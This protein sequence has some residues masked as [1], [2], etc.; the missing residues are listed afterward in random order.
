MKAYCRGATGLAVLRCSRAWVAMLCALVLPSAFAASL[1]AQEGGGFRLELD[2]GGHRGVIRALAFD[3]AGRWLFSASDDKTVRVWDVAEGR[4]AMT[5]RGQIGDGEEGMIFAVAPS[6]DSAA[7]AVA[8]Y[9]APVGAA[10]GHGVIRIHDRRSGRLTQRLE[11]RRLPVFALAYDA[12]RDELV[13]AG[14][15]GAVQRWRAPFSEAPEALPAL[16]AD[17]RRVVA[18]GWALGG[19]RL[20]AATGDYGLRIWDAQTGTPLAPP[21]AATLWDAG[22]V[23]LAVSPDGAA[24]AIGGEAG[25]VQVRAAEDGRLLAALPEVAFRPD[26]L[27]FLDDERLLIGCGYRCLPGQASLVVHWP[28]GAV[29]AEHGGLEGLATAA[30]VAPD[31]TVALAGGWRHEIRLWQPAGGAPDRVLVGEG[32]PVFAVAL[33]PDGDGIAWG[34][35]HPCPER[36]ACPEVMGPLEGMLPLPAGARR[37]DVPQPHGAAAADWLRARH[38]AKPWGLRAVSD[39]RFETAELELQGPGGLRTLYKRGGTDGWYHAAFTLLPEAGALVTGGGNGFLGVHRLDDLSLVRVLEGHSADVTAM[40]AAEAEG[41]L[42]TGGTDQTIRLWNLVTGE[43]VASFFFTGTA[44]GD[45]WIVWTPQ[46]YYHSSPGGD[47]LIGWHINQGADREGRLMRSYQ[48][49]RHLHS[50]EIVERALRL[51][52]ARDAALELRGTDGELE[53]LLARPAPE[54]EMR[55]VEEVAVEPGFAVIELL[56]GAGAAEVDFAVLVNDRR[57]AAQPV[58]GAAP[59]AQRYVIPVEAGENA[60]LVTAEDE[61]GYITTRGAEAIAAAPQSAMAGGRLR[62]AVVGIQDYPLLP[63][64]C[65]GRSCDLSFPLADAVAF[66]EVLERHAA[67]LFSGVERLVMLNEGALARSPREAAA[68]AAL[69]GQTRVIEPEARAVTFELMDFLEEAQDPRDTTVVF[70]AGHGIVL[71]EDYYIIPSDGQRRDAQSWRMASLVDWRSIQQAMERAQGRRV[72]VLDT[73]HA[74][75][76][77]NQRLEKDAADARISVFAAT[78]PTELAGE[79]ARLGHG[80]FTHAMVEGLRG[81]ARSADGVWALG[82]AQFVSDEVRRLSGETQEPMFHF[83]QMRNFLMARP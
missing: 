57:V 74:A 42:V 76:A 58:P 50:P 75:G 4:S 56:E 3:D 38:V 63:D 54:F 46:G 14:Q 16:E 10:E 65:N 41:V 39:G 7:V 62:I 20:V 33:A 81:A 80:I 40:A 25:L 73:C 22:L 83:P 26:A 82:L 29:V 70:I 79:T 77:F 47:R 61:A 5:L 55:L 44:P 1:Q 19:A 9:L 13:A 66:L 15:G 36:V 31:G 67:P 43:L 2:T 8:G 23:A 72:L 37:L 59:G 35:A 28:S 11:G 60:I 27:A 24:I 49:K 17:A 53:R 68:L 48:L 18:M 69:G 34:T 78:G 6:A 52:S 21:D 32:A 45:D 51:G 30:A 71:G 12:G 64:G